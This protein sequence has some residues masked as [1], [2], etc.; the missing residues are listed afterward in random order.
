MPGKL[1]P[2]RIGALVSIL[3]FL[4][5]AVFSWWPGNEARLLTWEL[6]S[7]NLEDSDTYSLAPFGD[8]LWA[9]GENN[10]WSSKDGSVWQR[11]RP[12][13]GRL[14]PPGSYRR[15]HAVE[16]KGKLWIL[17]GSGKDDVWSSADGENWELACDRL[18]L[19]MD[20]TSRVAV[21]RDQLWVASNISAPTLMC[22]QDGRRWREVPMTKPFDSVGPALL[23]FKNRLWLAGSAPGQFSTSEDGIEW[24]RVSSGFPGGRRDGF[25]CIC[26]DDKLWV[27]GGWRPFGFFEKIKHEPL[28]FLSLLNMQGSSSNPKYLSD[29]WYSSDGVTWACNSREEKKAFIRHL[30]F[31]LRNALCLI[32]HAGNYGPKSYISGTLDTLWKMAKP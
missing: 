9:V 15:P 17:Y 31:V 6:L 3:L 22:T 30:A 24:Q 10:L 32:G 28:F 7:C 8:R 27:I 25:Q 13:P 29:S 11:V 19:S 12:T 1:S 21:F 2:I 20:D 18:P 5:F 4:F 14:R 23:A 26:F 16:F